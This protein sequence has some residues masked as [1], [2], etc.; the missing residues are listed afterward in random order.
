MASKPRTARGFV[1]GDTLTFDDGDAP[2]LPAKRRPASAATA[3]AAPP[4]QRPAKRRAEPAAAA[5]AAAA[6]AADPG[7]KGWQLLRK[8]GWRPGAGLGKHEHGDVAPLA[9]RAQ[10]GTRGVGF[11]QGLVLIDGKL[12]AEQPEA[13]AAAGAAAGS[14][15]AGA[16]PP[17]PAAAAQARAARPAGPLTEA[18][19]RRRRGRKGGGGGGGDGA[20]LPPEVLTAAARQE[21]DNRKLKAIQAA[22]RREFSAPT[23]DAGGDTNPLT[24]RNKLSATNP[25]LGDGDDDDDF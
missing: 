19:D 23:T 25:L 17:G 9:P 21:A 3:A 12:L 15:A 20:Q 1:K 4:A 8:A 5:P 10:R 14:A 11:E 16:A 7:G 6:P 18:A 2:V 13:A 24:R 22:L